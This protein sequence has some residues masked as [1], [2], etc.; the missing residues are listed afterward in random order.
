MRDYLSELIA[1]VMQFVASL[2]WVIGAVM[3]GPSSHVDN[4]YLAAGAAW[5]VAC[6]ASAWGLVTELRLRSLE[7]RGEEKLETPREVRA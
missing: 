3:A 6:T 2:C 4:L 7:R 1:L 5:F